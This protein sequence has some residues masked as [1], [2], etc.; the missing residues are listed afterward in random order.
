M[1][2][3][4]VDPGLTRCGVAVVDGERGRSPRL[5]AS[6]VLT[7]SAT[8]HHPQRL[9][10]IWEEL[11]AL[12]EVHHPDAVAVEEVFSQQ[13][14]R[15]VMGTAQVAGLVMVCAQRRGLPLGSHTPT[16]VKA[17]V[18]GHG[19]ANKDQVTRMV[20]RLL[21]LQQRPQP[22]DAADAM[23]LA[24]CHIWRSGPVGVRR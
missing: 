23:A 3:L 12:V 6:V 8:A 19:R 4:G 10:Q 13:N 17:S 2:V 5:V 22:A 15:S 14:V 11:D 7:S 20:M 18:T 21:D 16:E 24:I 9:L 1:R